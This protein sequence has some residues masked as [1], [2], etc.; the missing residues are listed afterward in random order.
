MSVAALLNF[1]RYIY[2][3]S[4]PD[5]AQLFGH[6]CL[7]QYA[8][9]GGVIGNSCS[10]AFYVRYMRVVFYRGGSIW[11]FDY[12]T[13]HLW[14]RCVHNISSFQ[15]SLALCASS[16]LRVLKA[17]RKK[18]CMFITT[19]VF[20][21]LYTQLEGGWRNTV[22]LISTRFVNIQLSWLSPAG[23]VCTP[24]RIASNVITP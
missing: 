7:L 23:I 14:S 6:H 5:M 2:I 16:F 11:G 18:C 12:L 10:Q 15:I 13:E 8:E 22:T 19:H 1:T 4:K 24:S 17:Y 3:Q 21:S 20:S 9:G